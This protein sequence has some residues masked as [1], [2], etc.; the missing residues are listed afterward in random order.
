LMFLA[1]CGDMHRRQ[2][3]TQKESASPARPNKF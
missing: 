3:E 2:R 1:G